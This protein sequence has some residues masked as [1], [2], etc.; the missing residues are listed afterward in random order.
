MKED[1]ID[2]A[3]FFAGIWAILISAGLFIFIMDF[4]LGG[5]K[6][7][8][9]ATDFCG[10]LAKDVDEFKSCVSEYKGE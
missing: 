1:F 9:D 4:T 6:E 10:E 2:G 3:K 5:A 8:E 7:H